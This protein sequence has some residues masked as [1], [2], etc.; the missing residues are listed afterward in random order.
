MRTKILNYADNFLIP[1]RPVPH[2]PLIA[3]L[4]TML[5]ALFKQRDPIG[6]AP[7]QRRHVSRPSY[8][9]K[10]AKQNDKLFRALL[11]NNKRVRASLITSSLYH[12]TEPLPP[13]ES[14][15]ADTIVKTP[16]H[17]VPADSLD[18]AQQL[19]AHRKRD[20]LVLNMANATVP[21]GSYLDG[22]GA[23]EEALC[24]R[25]TL[26]L[27]IGPERKFH[28]IPKHGAIYS[29]YVLVVRKSDEEKCVTLDPEERWWTSV[30]SVAAI[31]RPLLNESGTDF[32][33]HENKE[34][35]RERIRTVLRVAA[36]ERKKNLVL[37]A[38]GCGAFRNPPEAVAKLMKEVLREKEF[39]GRFE[40][41]W[42]SVMDRRGSGNYDIFRKAL[43]GLH[44]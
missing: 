38:L 13:L 32:A 18:T 36:L 42:F 3:S 23:Q 16:I 14:R 17:V 37:S 33:L 21:G 4:Q 26:Y 9:T 5:K 20:I 27:A 24:R 29:P 44:I 28:P 35:M 41:I 19:V 6:P 15:S 31:T 43:D 2:K 34:D 30:I 39:S 25:S 12:Y 10:I 11:K 7:E 22:A 40:G 1:N 8:Y